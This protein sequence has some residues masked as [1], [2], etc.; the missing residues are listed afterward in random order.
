MSNSVGD[1]VLLHHVHEYHVQ[2]GSGEDAR[3]VRK[4]K[5]LS[6][7]SAIVSGV[8]ADGNVSIAV[9]KPD[10]SG[11]TVQDR[12]GDD[13]GY[14]VTAAPAAKATEAPATA[15]RI[16]ALEAKLADLEKAVAAQQTPPA[17]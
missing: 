3:S 9:F 1:L 14:V 12:I 7:K 4:T 8:D 15:K 13:S 6:T 17:K 5:I 10:Y 2:E 11:L 16:A